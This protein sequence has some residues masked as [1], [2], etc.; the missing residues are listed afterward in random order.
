MRFWAFSDLHQDFGEWVPP[1]RKKSAAANGGRPRHDAVIVAGDICEGF[2]N[3]IQWIVDAE[4]NEQPVIVLRGNH[5]SYGHDYDRTMDAARAVAARHPNI[6]ILQNDEL[7][8]GDGADRVRVLG[9]TLWTDYLL[10]SGHYYW[11]DAD[12]RAENMDRA[13][14]MLN[15]HRRIS[16]RG[17]LW[18]PEDALA[19]HEASTAWLA[20]RLDEPFDGP[21]LVV[22][23]HAPLG[24]SIDYGYCREAAA[25]YASDL[26][27]LVGKAQA[28][29]H[30]H[31]HRARNYRHLGCRVLA[32]PRG[33][34]GQSTGW[35]PNFTFEVDADGVEVMRR[36]GVTER[37][38][39]QP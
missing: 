5:E 11:S 9:A 37:Q 16:F 7:V 29:F 39:A 20:G 14:R 36:V 12:P 22:T 25:C 2:E 19:E 26:D 10:R 13:R 30:G 17:G 6:H 1:R 32:N 18:R 8:L 28:W 4:L 24:R 34:P 33:Y 23:H 3:G 15:D 35:S 21:T 31:I 27:E 38:A